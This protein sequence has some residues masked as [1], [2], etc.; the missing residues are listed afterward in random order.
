MTVTDQN[1]ATIGVLTLISAILG[2]VLIKRKRSTLCTICLEIK[3]VQSLILLAFIKHF[4]CFNLQLVQ[5]QRSNEIDKDAD[6]Y[7][8][9]QILF[10]CCLWVCHILQSQDYL[11][12]NSA[13]WLSD[14]KKCFCWCIKFCL[15]SQFLF[16]SYIL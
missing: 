9:L 15:F 10:F 5:L 16:L 3:T 8:R 7:Y 2:V 1:A 6:N 14:N 4:Y 13:L 11:W 12:K